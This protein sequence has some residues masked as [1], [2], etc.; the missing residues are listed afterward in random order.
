LLPSHLAPDTRPARRAAV[1]LAEHFADGRATAD[2][3]RQTER[4][5]LESLHAME[6]RWRASRGAERAAPAPTHEALALAGMATWSEAPKA[7]YYASS[8][9]YLAAASIENPGAMISSRRFSACQAA[10]ERAQTDLLRDMVANHFHPAPAVDPAWLAWN[11]GMIVRLAQAVY[12]E[13][14]WDRLPI[15]ADALEEA[16]CTDS[17]ILSHCRTAAVHARGCWLLDCLV[18]D[19][20]I[21]GWF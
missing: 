1:K 20:I 11:G 21:R 13:L 18:P 8:N 15:L 16:G 12:D 2:E 17:T 6:E 4:R 14:A 19:M 9:A 3:L 5:V 7:A 10:E